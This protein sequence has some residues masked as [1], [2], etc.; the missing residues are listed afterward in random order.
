MK[1][2]I[3]AKLFL[4][5]GILVAILISVSGYSYFTIKSLN[6]NAHEIN[7]HWLPSTD[8]IH[9]WSNLISTYRIKE[10]RMVTSNS[11]SEVDLL[12]KEMEAIESQINAKILEYESTIQDDLDR[13][14]FNDAKAKWVRY[15]D[16]SDSAITLADQDRFEE[17]MSIINGESLALFGSINESLEKLVKYNSDNADRV[18]DAG[19]SLF[20][21]SIAILTN[22]ILLAIVISVAIAF[23]LSF[24]MSKTIKKLLSAAQKV[25]GGDLTELVNIKSKD[26]F[27]MLAASFNK[28][29]VSLRELVSKISEG[30]QHIASMSEELTAGAEQNAKATELIA[31]AMQ[32][33]AGGAEKQARK[34]SETTYLVNDMLTKIN[35]VYSSSRQ[36]TELSVES[37]AAAEAGS[38]DVQSAVKQM[39]EI[40]NVVTA[41]ANI[42]IELGKKSEEI[43]QIVD[44]I[45][46]I[47]EQTNL[48]ALNA[49][50]EAARAGDAGRGFAVVADEVRKLAEQSSQ[51]TKNISDIVYEV[52]L[53]ADKSVD[54]MKNGLE[55]VR[56]GSDMINQTGSSFSKIKEAIEKVSAQIMEVNNAIED[57]S[58]KNSAVS[59]NIN[60]MLEIAELTSSGTQTAAS[61]A[62]EQTASIEE[63]ASSASTLSSTAE[64]LHSL[65]LRFKL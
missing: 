5:F 30:S 52:K 18:S 6:S 58:S 11:P 9:T 42:V 56:L 31:V 7:I 27:G 16:M 1:L 8:R 60:E 47:A 34:T 35:Q 65:V 36:V 50:I 45:T 10:Y 12:E 4:S 3:R 28:M 62:E 15:L 22:A 48:L 17:S 59:A 64:E 39:S 25:A 2:T 32:D 44:F 37:S 38:K 19:E 40:D 55:V 46:G 20:K 49:A 29:I 53:N 33:I 24:S 61:S 51:A 26:E 63:I 21:T 23:L 54:S 57:M 14:M 43:S 41:S 13:Q